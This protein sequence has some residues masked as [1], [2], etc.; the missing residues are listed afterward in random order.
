HL[1]ALVLDELLEPV[2]DVELLL[3]PDGRDVA[4][5]QE[6]IRIDRVGRRGRVAEIAGHDVRAT[7]PQLARGTG[8]AGDRI[9]LGPGGRVDNLELDVGQHMPD[10]ADR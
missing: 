1:V 7:D 2:D 6:T 10:G 3:R 5:S 4:G 9:D 8:A